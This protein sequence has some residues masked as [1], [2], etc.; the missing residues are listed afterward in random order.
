MNSNIELTYNQANGTNIFVAYANTVNGLTVSIAIDYTKLL[1]NLVNTVITMQNLIGNIETSI[2][3]IET[4]IGNIETSIGNINTRGSSESLGF[5]T[6]EATMDGSL[7]RTEQR[8]ITV[9]A[10]KSSGG[11]ANVLIEIA[12]PTPL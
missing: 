5:F 12:N 6:N 4:S 11:L 3:N 7:T 10:I 1:S 2:G 9:S 8:A